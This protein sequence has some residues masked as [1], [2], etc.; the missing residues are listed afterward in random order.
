LLCFALLFSSLLCSAL[1]HINI[2][3]DI[4]IN[5]NTNMTAT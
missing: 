3:I 2:N 1:L 4:S 5:I